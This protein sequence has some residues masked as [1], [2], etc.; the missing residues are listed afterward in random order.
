MVK[1]CKENGTEIVAC[2]G[3]NRTRR[4]GPLVYGNTKYG[5]LTWQV[6][7]VALER[8][9]LEIMFGTDTSGFKGFLESRQR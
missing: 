3:R 1:K 7:H 4:D 9:C 8:V 5:D 6:S 2:I